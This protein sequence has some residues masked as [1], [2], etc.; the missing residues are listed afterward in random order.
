MKRLMRF[1][2]G[3]LFL[4]AGVNHFFSTDFY[5]NIMPGYLP[6]HR[7]LVYLS[8]VTE[9]AAGAMLFFGATV[10]IGAWGIVAMLVVFLL[11]HV[12]MIVQHPDKHPKIAAEFL[13]LRLVLQFP[14]IAWA[15]WFTRPERK[16]TVE[17]TA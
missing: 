15:W 14:M 10:R 13:Y 11:V 17:T 2:L 4:V 1:L 9:I 12:D 3:L 16:A 5:V 8:G 6:M 7:E